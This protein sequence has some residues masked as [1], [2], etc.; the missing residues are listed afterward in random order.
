MRVATT[1]LV[2]VE[3]VVDAAVIGGTGLY[4]L[5]PD[6]ER[7]DVATPYGKPSSSITVHEVG[8]RR[9]AFLA[10]HGDQHQYPA[11]RVPY[12]ANIWALASLGVTRVLAPCA[13]GSLHATIPPGTFV[14]PDQIIDRTHGRDATFYEGVAVHVEFADPYCSEL[15]SHAV[16]TLTNSRTPSRPHG[17]VVVIPGPRFG[18]RAEAAWYRLAGGD[19]VNMTAMP[20]AA[21]ARELGLCYCN[22][23]VVTDYDAGV[24][25]RSSVTQQDVVEQFAASL[26]SL[27]EVLVRTVSELPATTSCSCPRPPKLTRQ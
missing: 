10:R 23:A 20:E 2:P 1:Y 3:P 16:A 26:D 5:L 14:V 9:V 17:T 21:L 25:E 24:G 11:H 6:G 7:F 12:R 19:L 22:I 18:T 15:R 13:V 27:R 4:A 8:P